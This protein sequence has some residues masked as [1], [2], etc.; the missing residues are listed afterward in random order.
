[1]SVDAYIKQILKP[2]GKGKK[3]V[4]ILKDQYQS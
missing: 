4:Y 1:M 3:W 2:N